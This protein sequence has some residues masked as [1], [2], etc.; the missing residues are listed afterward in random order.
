SAEKKIVK[1]E[2]ESALL[3]LRKIL[4]NYP[5]DSFYVRSLYSVGWIYEYA[6]KNKDSSLAYYNK[7]KK[8]FPNS[9]YTLSV[10]P[11]LEFY[12][13]YDKRDTTKTSMDTT[14]ILPD[15]LKSLTDSSGMILD[16]ANIKIDNS[17]QP[18]KE[19]KN[20]VKNKNQ[21]DN[22]GENPPINKPPE[23]KK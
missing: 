7:L 9:Q 5:A 1:N 21:K 22:S 8:D 6:Y 12:E 2:Y 16:P 13:S 17:G 15:S 14:G 11:K 23:K 18:E 10:N 20:P 3:D 4:Y 19:N